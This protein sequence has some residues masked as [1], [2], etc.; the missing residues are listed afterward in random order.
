MKNKVLGMQYA[1]VSRTEDFSVGVFPDVPSAT[2]G[3]F[4]GRRVG[5]LE[6]VENRKIFDAQN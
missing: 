2:R 4:W 3:A 6:R 1:P 5:A